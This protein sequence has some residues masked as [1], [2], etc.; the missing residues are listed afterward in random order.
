MRHKAAD[1]VG[2]STERVDHHHARDVAA[3][4][5]IL[6]QQLAAAERPG[7]RDHRG[8]PIGQAMRGLDETSP[9]QPMTLLQT[10]SA[11]KAT[12]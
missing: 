7:G 1:I 10:L 8:D 11:L 12:L 5:Y 2:I 6:G 4:S 9:L 3:V